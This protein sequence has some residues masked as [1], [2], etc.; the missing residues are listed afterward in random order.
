MKRRGRMRL[1]DL[2]AHLRAQAERQLSGN[3]TTDRDPDPKPSV[4]HADKGTA[5]TVAMFSRVRITYTCYRHR[6]IDWENLFTKHLTD[7]LVTAGI[8][9]DDAPKFMP[10]Q[11]RLIQVQVPQKEPERTVIKI[12][13]LEPEPSG[14]Q[15]ARNAPGSA[16]AC[17]RPSTRPGAATLQGGEKRPAVAANPAMCPEAP[18][19][20][21]CNK[22][23]A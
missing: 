19:T 22:I 12:E 7:A 14:S 5:G 21:N 16:R 23:G 9:P 3:R 18:N 4:A 6:V 13:E 15:N 17:P 20:E 1:E 10:E 8:F 11:P 2:P